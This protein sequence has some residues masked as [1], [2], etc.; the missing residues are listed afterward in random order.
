MDLGALINQFGLPVALLVYFIWRDYQSSK[1][2]FN[3][4]RDIAQKSVQSIDKAT[5]SIKEATSVI[6][7]NNQHISDNSDI[8]NEV[9]GVLSMRGNSNGT[10]N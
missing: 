10:G 7:I 8:L 1:E 9:K 5:E 2:R 3:D 6:A 4:M